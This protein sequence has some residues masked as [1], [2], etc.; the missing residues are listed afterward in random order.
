LRVNACFVLG[1]DGHTPEVF[2]EVFHFV[3][4]VAPFDVQITYQT[5][6][7]GTPLYQR[8]KREGRLT[9]DGQWN[10]CTLFDINYAP[11]P[12]TDAELRAGFHDLTRR[13]YSQE[14]TAWRK[15]EFKKQRCR[16]SL[17]HLR[18]RIGAAS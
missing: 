8:L 15:E 16:G 10:R 5:P 2:D 3:E 6:F 17:H 11:R 18:N 4:E 7:P 1:L 14:F 13:L 9:H 12:M